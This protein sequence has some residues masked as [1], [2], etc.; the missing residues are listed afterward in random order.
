MQ[1]G[2][3]FDIVLLGPTGYT[4]KLCAE[5]VVKNLPTNLKWALAGRSLQKIENVAQSLK[6]LNPDR[7][8]PEIIAVQLNTAE[9]RSLAER[10]KI[11]INA[12]GPYH[13]YSTPV[14]EA[15]ALCGTHYLDATGETPW[16]KQTVEKYHETAK[17]N[18]AIIIHSVGI[19]SAPPDML[20][21]AIVKE[22]REKLSCHT[23]KVTGAV[24]ELKSSGASGGTLSTILLCIEN[25]SKADLLNSTQPFSLAASQPPK[26]IPPEPIMA[27]ILGVRTVRDLGTLTNSPT[28][29]C[30]MTT[31]HRSSTLMPEFYGPRFYFRQF[32]R[33]R[34]SFVGILFRFA[35][36]FGTSLLLL[37]PVRWLV[38]KIIY[39]P[40]SGP[41]EESGRNDRYEFR[42]IA[43]PDQDTSKRVLGK[44]N[45]EG[46][47]Y[48][49][50]GL[51][52]AEAAMVILENEEKV[53]RVSRGG[54]VTPAV[55]GQEYLDRLEKVG[56]HVET[57]ML[58]Y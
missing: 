8:D 33:V 55:L 14:V 7:A 20:V 51:L 5:H 43:T 50:T 39:A 9:L 27:R 13:V 44:L 56:C 12:V 36:L 17:S 16:V 18:G 32:M 45:F 53:K 4:G 38:R 46:P 48:L 57:Q 25:F 21:W 23:R 47:M 26:D 52:M 41:T 19:E 1:S 11:L 24:H 37:A 34:N 3:E 10:T 6:K 2:R 54:I 40:G 49:F 42:A 58:D 35:F 15:C 31:V 22:V 29:F 30:D 28:D